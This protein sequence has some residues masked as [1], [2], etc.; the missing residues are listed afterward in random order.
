[1]PKRRAPKVPVAGSPFGSPLGKKGKTDD[2]DDELPPIKPSPFAN[3][4]GNATKKGPPTMKIYHVV[5]K[6]SLPL[7]D[8]NVE[9]GEE[10]F[11]IIIEG[12]MQ[13][14]QVQC[15]YNKNSDTKAM[16]FVEA[17][18]PINHVFYHEIEEDPIMLEANNGKSYQIKLV[19]FKLDGD[20]IATQEELIQFATDTFVP[21]LMRQKGVFSSARPVMHPTEPYVQVPSWNK[22]IG[23]GAG[24]IS[25]FSFAFKEGSET[26]G[27]WVRTDRANLYSLFPIGGIPDE[28]KQKYILTDH[29]LLAPDYLQPAPADEE[30]APAE[31]GNDEV[32][33]P[34]EAGNDLVDSDD[35]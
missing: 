23:N 30:V 33:A 24:L 34:A 35:E 12:F 3:K 7:E 19:C 11:T 5:P 22:I 9:T 26:F 4:L 17:T 18:N 20:E 16:E 10:G 27:Q 14:K 8:P 25:L 32:V 2:D 15:I 31:A 29:H 13:N 21:A 6:V 28:F 1:M